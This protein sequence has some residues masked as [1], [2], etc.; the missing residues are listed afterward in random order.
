MTTRQKLRWVSLLY[1]AEGF[2]FGVARTLLPACFTFMGM[3]PTEIGGLSSILQAPWSAKL[4]WA[5]LVDRFGT[6]RRWMQIALATAAVA[7]VVLAAVPLVP[8]SVTLQL[9]LLVFAAAGATQDIAIDAFTV[10]LLDR[11]EEGVANGTRV[12][13]YRA[14]ML[15][16]SGAL[17]ALGGWIGWRPALA[18]GAGVALL[19]A[20]A[21]L[22][23]P[24]RDRV[25]QPSG[26]FLGQLRAWFALPDAAG[27]FAFVVLYKLGDASMAPMIVPFWKHQGLTPNDVALVSASFGMVAT[28]AGALAGGVFTSRFGIFTALWV[29]GIA[30]AVSNLGYAAAASADA[31]RA[32][33]YAASLTESFTSGLGTAAAMSFM[34]RICDKRQ[35][36]TQLAVITALSSLGGTL[37]TAVSGIGVDRFGFGPY[38]LLT[39]LLSFPAYAFLPFVRRRLVQIDST[40][41]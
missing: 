34:M 13:A 28:I 1:F 5:P 9:T 40:E 10:E 16:A 7:L 38:F 14:G 30:Q 12:A 25:P 15:V 22:A 2:P 17:V 11:G 3:T 32:G 33:I 37:A 29:L 4:F 27:V 6:R 19:I 39:F 41:S 21:E 35:A 20:V 26:E 24:H 8:I 18:C 31:G 36:A 23:L